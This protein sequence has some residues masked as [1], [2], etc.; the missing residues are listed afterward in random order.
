MSRLLYHAAGWEGG[1]PSGRA[2]AFDRW[3]PLL[4]GVVGRQGGWGAEALTTHR[5]RC[6]KSNRSSAADRPPSRFNRTPQAPFSLTVRNVQPAPSRSRRGSTSLLGR[7]RYHRLVQCVDAN[8]LRARISPPYDAHFRR[9]IESRDSGITPSALVD[10]VPPLYS[11]AFVIIDNLKGPAYLLWQMYEYVK[12]D[13]PRDAV[14]RPRGIFVITDPD[15]QFVKHFRGWF[16]R[17]VTSNKRRALTLD[18][19]GSTPS[20]A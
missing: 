9:V 4:A 19:L 5:S 15:K 2:A 17:L 16:N 14:F 1:Q 13:K 11:T 12:A 6:T 10:L 20:R 8:E 18:D 7:V 3:L